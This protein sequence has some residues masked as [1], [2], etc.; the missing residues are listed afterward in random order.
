MRDNTKLYLRPQICVVA[1]AAAAHPCQVTLNIAHAAARPAYRP[2]CCGLIWAIPCTDHKE[3]SGIKHKQLTDL[4][5]DAVHLLL[6]DQRR[7]NL[8]AG[9]Q[10]CSDDSPAPLH[11]VH[12]LQ[13]QQHQV[14]C[15]SCKAG[16]LLQNAV[17]RVHH[18]GPMPNCSL[19][20]HGSCHELRTVLTSQNPCSDR[21]FCPA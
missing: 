21:A 10:G 18:L 13:V 6:H 17:Q 7:Q 3:L 14:V 11:Q 5:P 9:A 2:S 15:W 1:V 20:D 19:Q 4:V 8:T 16:L 12:P